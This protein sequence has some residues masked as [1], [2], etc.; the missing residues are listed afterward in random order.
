[1]T[2]R[3]VDQAGWLTREQRA[4]LRRAGV[5]A[6]SIARIQRREPVGRSVATRAARIVGL[7]VA[8]L[9]LGPDGRRT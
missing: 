2:A 4:A 1:M 3:V 6:W 5:S 8:A 7:T 9:M